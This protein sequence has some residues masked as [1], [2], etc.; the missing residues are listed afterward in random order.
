MGHLSYR[1]DN[2]QVKENQNTTEDMKVQV[3]DNGPLLVHGKITLTLA[4]GSVEEKDKITAF[5]RCGKTGNNPFCDG[6]HK[7]G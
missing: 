1:R 6:T 2:E 7:Q 4:N 5:C 3:M